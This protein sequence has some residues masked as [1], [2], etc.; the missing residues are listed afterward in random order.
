VFWVAGKK[1]KNWQKNDKFLMK[2]KVKKIFKKK[3][4]KKRKKAQKIAKF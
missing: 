4:K 1:T 3:K 2:K